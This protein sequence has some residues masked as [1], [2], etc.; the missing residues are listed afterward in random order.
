MTDSL[1]T[2]PKTF[3]V[4]S[5]DN[6][7]TIGF[8][9]ADYLQPGE[10]VTGVTTKLTLN[11]AAGPALTDPPEFTATFVSQAIIGSALTA[12]NNYQ[13]WWIVSLSSGD[14]PTF[15]TWVLIQQ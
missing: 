10:T 1:F 2:L 13:L 7:R 14:T 3:A 8:D 11:G 15:F 4:A 6:P 5:T 12:P 9:L